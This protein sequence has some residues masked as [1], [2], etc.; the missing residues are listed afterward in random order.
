MSEKEIK[1]SRKTMG[2]IKGSSLATAFVSAAIAY[3][4]SLN[5]YTKSRG[6]LENAV[7]HNY[8]FNTYSYL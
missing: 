4:W 8:V 7:N 2:G 5:V 6:V 1:M 3:D